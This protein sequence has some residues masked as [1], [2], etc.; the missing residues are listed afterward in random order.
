MSE[1]YIKNSI[2]S[3]VSMQCIYQDSVFCMGL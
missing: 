2:R 1:W 3:I